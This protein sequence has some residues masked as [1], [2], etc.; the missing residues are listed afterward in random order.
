MRKIISL[1]GKPCAGKGTWLRQFLEG[2][3]DQ[4][5]VVSCGDVLRQEAEKETILGKQAKHYMDAGKLIPDYI[6]I[7]LVLDQIR[8]TPEDMSLILDGFPRTKEQADAALEC[9]M[10]ITHVVNLKVSDDEAMA[11]S[12]I[13]VICSKC[14]ETY[15]T[16]AFKK[17]KK[18][19][20]CDK[21]GTKLIKRSDDKP[22]VM[23]KR[24]E[25]FNR[26][27]VPAIERMKASGVEYLEKESRF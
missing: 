27:T 4:Y 9:Q 11:R 10:G 15:T 7:N 19:G 20:V 3:E 16:G 26:D 18:E 8:K 24:L 6:I 5:K 2:K 21:C 14:G 13:R 22:E 12:A 1:L 23:K 25:V 17:P